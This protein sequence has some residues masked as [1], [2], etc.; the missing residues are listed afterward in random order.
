MKPDAW[1]EAPL[2]AW[3]PVLGCAWRWCRWDAGPAPADGRMARP[4]PVGQWRL[5]EGEWR[6]SLG[7]AGEIGFP[8]WPGHPDARAALAWTI[9]Q[10]HAARRQA[11]RDAALAWIAH[12]VEA[13][14]TDRLPETLAWPDEEIPF[15][16]HL[17]GLWMEGD[18]GGGAG[19]RVLAELARH[20]VVGWTPLRTGW[21]AVLV[22]P[23][24][25]VDPGASPAG[26]VERRSAA[27]E[28]FEDSATQKT[29]AH[30][31]A[32]LVD[33]L[34]ADAW[35]SA[36]AA[37]GVRMDHP[38]AWR[39]GVTTLAESL[40]VQ[41]CSGQPRVYLW[42]ADPV[43]H[44]WD[45]APAAARMRFVEAVSQRAPSGGV[46]LNREAAETLEGMVRANLNVSEASRLLYLHRNTL[47][48]RIERIRQQTGYDVR[49]FHDA[50]VLW[51]LHRTPEGTGEPRD[52]AA[53]CT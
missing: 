50:M 33:V 18:A 4:A 44:L 8:G 16:S 53:T 22:I 48:N 26:P 36:R 52:G 40:R 43:A 30:H 2:R 24:P 20:H 9:R 37:A 29:L 10:A 11:W 45:A 27:V 7:W 31:L 6:L 3:T 1:W 19:R 35:V 41:E 34:A 28:G 39:R 51:L 32:G 12:A 42:G 38:G 5:D 47:M 17:A 14:A 46:R 23:A 15:P 13:G 25:D 49:N 21:L